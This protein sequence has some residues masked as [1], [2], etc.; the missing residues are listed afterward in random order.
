MPKFKAGDAVR[1]YWNDQ[2]TGYPQMYH[3]PAVII[4]RIHPTCFKC[5]FVGNDYRLPREKWKLDSH[6]HQ[7][8]PSDMLPFD[9][10]PGAELHRRREIWKAETPAEVQAAWRKSVEDLKRSNAELNRKLGPIFARILSGK[11]A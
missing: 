4:K 6:Q 5:A 8:H 11:A 9:L 3:R 2:A 7:Q 10:D 1:L